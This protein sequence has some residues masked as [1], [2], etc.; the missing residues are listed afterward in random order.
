MGAVT[1]AQ[2]SL[3]ARAKAA[4]DQSL[5]LLEGLYPLRADSDSQDVEAIRAIV[6]SGLT[7]L[8]YE[9]GQVGGPREQRVNALFGSLLG[10]RPSERN[11]EE[12]GGLLGKLRQEFG[13]QRA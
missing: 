9:L 5:P 11:P 3:Y 12:V 13:L 10:N 7:E 1:G 6:R 8:V 2:A 4:L